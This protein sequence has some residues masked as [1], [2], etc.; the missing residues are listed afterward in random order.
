[1][2]RLTIQDYLTTRDFLAELWIERD[3]LGFSALPGH[4]QRDL[5]DYFAPSVPMTVHE[6][7]VHRQEMT[8]VF[9]SL[10]QKA[11]RA[12]E[13]LRADLEGRPNQ[14]LDRHRQR[15]SGTFDSAGKAHR[16]RVAALA[17]PKVDAL[18]LARAIVALSKADVDGTLLAKARKLRER[19]D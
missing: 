18:R 12:A 19:R 2:P 9:P 6:A 3:G 1:M 17:R 11:G 7:T 10:P 13:A 5:H 14:M 4:A 16:I 8:K 15:T